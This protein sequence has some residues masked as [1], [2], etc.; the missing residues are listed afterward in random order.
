MLVLVVGE[1]CLDVF[2][3]GTCG[4]LCPEAPVPVFNSIN[5]VENLGM[6]YNVYNNLVS[7]GVNCN[8]L[9]NK[10]YRKI[11]KTRF[12][13]EAS[14]HM[15]MR[16]DENDSCY[17]RCRVKKINFSLYDAIVIS[18]YNKG[19][20]T[21]KD[22]QYIGD[23]HDLVFLD[24][25]KILGP[26]ANN[27]TYIKIN[28]S[29]YLLTKKEIDESLEDKL[30]I[31]RGPE[32]AEHKGVIYPVPKV[33][34]RDVSGAGDTFLAGMV[35]KYLDSKSIEQSIQFGN[36]CATSVVQTRGVSCV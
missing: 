11:S 4:R 19:Y 22:I 1:S 6:C 7:L 12:I 32:G 21:T 25:K 24:T 2:N 34:I 27:M 20:L 31:T 17:G 26:W 14:N 3:Y 28:L 35:S 23:H 8:I 36:E 9:T 29:E 15:F 13:D 18:D 16:L 33:S 30:V 10:N 5:R